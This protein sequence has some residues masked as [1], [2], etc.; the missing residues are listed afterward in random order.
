MTWFA[1]LWFAALATIG[2]VDHAITRHK[3]DMNHCKH[4]Y[5][6]DL[7]SGWR[8]YYYLGVNY[9]MPRNACWL[10]DHEGGVTCYRVAKL[11]LPVKK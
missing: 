8:E 6:A 1:T 3:L 7:P 9:C 2:V 11:V 5:A 4:Y 10:S